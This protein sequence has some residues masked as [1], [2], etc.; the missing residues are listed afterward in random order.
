MKV[1][2]QSSK[3]KRKHVLFGVED[4]EVETGDQLRRI[5]YPSL[6]PHPLNTFQ[7][8]E[9]VATPRTLSEAQFEY[10]KEVY[11]EGSVMES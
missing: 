4:D 10:M 1:L 2:S 11:L 3:V 9:L 6:L 5:S 8:L 7:Y